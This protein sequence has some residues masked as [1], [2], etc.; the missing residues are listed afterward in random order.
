M[1]WVN[2]SRRVTADSD[3]SCL[4]IEVS[5]SRVRAASGLSTNKRLIALEGPHPDLPLAINLEQR[6]PAIG[7]AGTA[8]VRL[9]P[10]AVCDEFLPFLGEPRTWKTGRHR[11]DP[12][13]AVSLLFETLRPLISN[14]TNVFLG[15][16]SYLTQ[17]QAAVLAALAANSR[18][19]LAGTMSS[20]LAL[21][22]ERAGPLTSH[23]QPMSEVE[24]RVEGIVPLYRSGKRQVPADVVVVDVDDHALTCGMIRVEP[25]QVSLTATTTLPGAGVKRWKKAMLDGVSDRCIRVCRRDPRDSAE[26]DQSLYEQIDDSLDRVRGGQHVVLSVHAAHWYQDLQVQPEDFESYCSALIRSSVQG[27]REVLNAASPS[28]PSEPPR[29]LWMTHEAG[30]LPGLAAAVRQNMAERT[31]VAVLRPESVAVA[32]A[33]LGER[34]PAAAGEYLNKVIPISAGKPESTPQAPTKKTRR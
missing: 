21:A 25:A 12:A 10:L 13:A 2:W 7:R 5:A 15:L 18:F 26:A 1:A 32:V 9:L 6:V 19:R 29:A 8:L 14:S 24:R 30:R 4:G 31:T 34:W 20:A 11:F 28:S 27:I 3:G 23:S 33:N 17:K 16:P 22:A